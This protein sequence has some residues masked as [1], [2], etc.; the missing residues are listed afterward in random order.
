M[1]LVLRSL[2]RLSN[3]DFGLGT[4]RHEAQQ[5]E[6]FE[7]QVAQLLLPRQDLS[8]REPARQGRGG[9]LRPARGLGL[10]PRDPTEPRTSTSGLF[11][12]S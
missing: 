9:Q 2:L 12:T 10:R 4:G 6:T 8:G 1:P 7:D 5:V 3:Q 11:W